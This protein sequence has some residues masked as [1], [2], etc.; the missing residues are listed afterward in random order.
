MT[1][2]MSQLVL[3]RTKLYTGIA[4]VQ[5]GVKVNTNMDTDKMLGGIVDI[6]LRIAQYMGIIIAIT[7]IFM[8]V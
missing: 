3:A 8:T 2:L 7:G 4:A 5:T 1:S 6:I